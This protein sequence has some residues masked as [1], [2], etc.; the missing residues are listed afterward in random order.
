MLQRGTD[1]T[2]LPGSVIG[3]QISGVVNSAN[4][5]MTDVWRVAKRP[6]NGPTAGPEP[7]VKQEKMDSGYDRAASNETGTLLGTVVPT[8][9]VRIPYP[10]AVQTTAGLRNIQPSNKK[11]RSRRSGNV[12]LTKAVN[13]GRGNS[14]NSI[15]HHRPVFLLPHGSI[16]PRQGSFPAVFPRRPIVVPQAAQMYRGGPTMVS[17]PASSNAPVIVFVSKPSATRTTLVQTGLAASSSAPFRYPVTHFSL[18]MRPN[19]VRI[20]SDKL[21][22]LKAMIGKSVL[23]KYVGPHAPPSDLHMPVCSKHVCQSCRDEFV[24]DVGLAD[25]LSRHSMQISFSCGCR[26]L[27]WPQTFCNPCTF[28]IFYRSHCD[29]PGPHASRDSVVI[30]TMDLDT[31]EYHACV[32]AR[33]QTVNAV[34]TRSEV[35]QSSENMNNQQ[36]A[37]ITADSS[38]NSHKVP[39]IAPVKEIYVNLEVMP[40]KLGNKQVLQREEVAKDTTTAVLT[41]MNKKRDSKPATTANSGRARKKFS[42]DGLLL[43][44]VK[45]FSDALCHNRTKCP[46]CSVDYKTRDA[47]LAH[48]SVNRLKQRL[49]CADCGSVL[50]V[51]GFNAHRRLHKNRRPFVCPQCGIVFDEAKSVAVFKAHVELCCFH[52]TQSSSGVSTSNCPRCSFHVTE[53]DERK[54]IRHIVDTHAVI[55]YKCRS[56]PKAFVNDSAAKRHSENAGHDAQKDIVRKC[57]LCDAVF[58]GDTGVEMQTHVMEHRNVPLFHCPV[59][60][61]PLSQSAI[62]EHM[63]SCH[64]DKILPATT[65]EVCSQPSANIEELFTHVSTKHANYFLSIMKCLPSRIESTS[66]MEDDSETQ[67]GSISNISTVAESASVSESEVQTSTSSSEVFECARCQTKF[68]SKA[69]YKRHQAKHR[70]LESK[71]ASKKHAVAKSSSD[72]LEQVF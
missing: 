43:A 8:S 45:D 36:D 22:R 42:V 16:V 40:N 31:P 35:T 26:L 61:L 11:G 68:T 3:G 18:P 62:A 70:F 51:C 9:S 24:T 60:S 30:S 38:S 48:F 47:L 56:C 12:R 64:L 59:C 41:K 44:K 7:A 17:A 67:N 37:T 57:P 5:I 21:A 4:C 72:P 69:I 46:E 54:M 29:E 20:G 33:N 13:V 32:E 6:L 71:K 27:K 52:L 53:A 15:V 25:H 39:A 66:D 28:E 19:N 2:R 49:R 50:S 14:H 65:C 10:V 55:Y 58:K 23:D 1:T 63:R 34:T